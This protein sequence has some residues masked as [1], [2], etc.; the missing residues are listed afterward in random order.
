MPLVI[1][2]GVPITVKAFVRL[3]V[4]PPGAGFVAETVCAPS[5]AVEGIVML[6]VMDVGLFTVTV[7]T[8]M[9][10]PKLTVVTP[11][12]KLL[13]VRVTFKV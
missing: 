9:S 5:V 10:P 2:G 6:A 3:A 4:P 12:M 7:L 13:P 11:P 1:C 8:V